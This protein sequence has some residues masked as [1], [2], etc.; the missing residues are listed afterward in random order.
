MYKQ[1]D[2]NGFH[3]HMI[4]DLCNESVINGELIDIL[5]RKYHSSVGFPL[6]CHLAYP[7]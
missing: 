7:T 5:F 6:F 4:F 1:S 2:G 3:I